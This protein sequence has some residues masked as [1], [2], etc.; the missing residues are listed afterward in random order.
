MPVPSVHRRAVAPVDGPGHP[1]ALGK[2]RIE[3]GQDCLFA[4]VHKG[5]AGDLLGVPQDI[6][7][8]GQLFHAASV[9]RTACSRTQKFF[10]KVEQP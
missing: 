3:D 4:R 7:G 6:F 5:A 9:R 1:L 10:H 8:F 2:E